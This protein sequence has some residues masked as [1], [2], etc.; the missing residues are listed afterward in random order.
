MHL[1]CIWNPSRLAR[2]RQTGCITQPSTQQHISPLRCVHR[3]L[4]NIKAK[5]DANRER[6]EEDERELRT[7]Q[8]T[9]KTVASERLI[10]VRT[11]CC[12]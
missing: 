1:E 5:A 2:A 6:E 10:S 4:S 7:R 8:R 9:Y 12:Y 3:L 11:N